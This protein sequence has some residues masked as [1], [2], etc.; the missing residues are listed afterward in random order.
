MNQFNADFS[1]LPQLAESVSRWAIDFQQT[2]SER[3][4]GC[5]NAPNLLEGGLPEVGLGAKQAFAEFEHRVAPFLNASAGPRYLGF[6]TGGTTPAAMLGD[7]LVSACD[8]NVA[9]PGDSISSAVELQALAWLRQL[10]ELPE[11]F[12]GILTSGATASNVLGV[13]CGRQFAGKQQGQDIARDGLAGAS[14][15]VFSATPH[16]SAQKALSFAGLGRN[17]FT[18]IARLDN[19]EAMDVNALALALRE[20]SAAGKIVLAS[21]GTVTGTD[22]DDLEAIAALCRAHQA[23]LH[24]DGAFGLFAR[25]SATRHAWT[26][27]IELADSITSDSH[28]WLNVPY[29]SGIFFTRHPEIL[30]QS[31]SVAAPYLD[32]ESSLPS[33][34][35]RGI[36]NSRR[37]R[38]LPLWFSLQ[39][40]GREGFAALIES[41]CAQASMLADWIEQS[42]GYE[43]LHPCRLN[44]VVFRP[45][46]DTVS[47]K[48]RL[49]QINQSGKVLLTP[50]MWDGK[51]AIRAAFSNWRTTTADVEIVCDIL[52]N[53]AM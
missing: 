45:T 13:I 4:V 33:F 28:K 40:Y 27:G 9:S 41:N 12:S 51:S 15:E 29:D 1:S 49:K 30:Q 11:E 36:E 6:V 32:V 47:V 46:S 24:V 18:Q 52:A 16:A 8:Q 35:D 37:F 7:W 53:C 31:C 21:A 23:W 42:P 50:G 17:Q 2:L 38:A 22:F 44:V 5:L 48:E 10:L 26:K 20:S 19:S 14:I 25:L 3:P 39:A 34:M 43:L